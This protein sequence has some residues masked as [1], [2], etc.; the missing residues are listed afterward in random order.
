MYSPWLAIITQLGPECIGIYPDHLMAG[1][2][3]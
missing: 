1:H 3:G 2:V